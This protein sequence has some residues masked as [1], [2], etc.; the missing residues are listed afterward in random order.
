MPAS[1]A[2]SATLE[3]KKPLRAK[4]LTAARKIASRLSTTATRT[5]TF[6]R[7]VLDITQEETIVSFKNSVKTK[8]KH[9]EMP[10][11]SP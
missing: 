3:L 8:Q 6:E 4:T 9:N 7:S 5:E 2:M 10:H 1:L 11:F